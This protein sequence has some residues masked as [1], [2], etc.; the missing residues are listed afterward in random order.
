MELHTQNLVCVFN[1]K[2]KHLEGISSSILLNKNEQ[3]CMENN[4]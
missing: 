2:K 1:D 4:R 3:F